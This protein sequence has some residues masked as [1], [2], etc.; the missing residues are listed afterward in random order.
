ME[1]ALRRRFGEAAA[2]TIAD[3]PGPRGLPIVGNFFQ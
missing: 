2:G 1:R 3:L